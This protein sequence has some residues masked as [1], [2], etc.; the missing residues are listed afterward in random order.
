MQTDVCFRPMLLQNSASSAAGP[1]GTSG[2]LNPNPPVQCLPG[3]PCCSCE[4]E[5]KVWIDPAAG[6]IVAARPG[7]AHCGHCPSL[8]AT[9]RIANSYEGQKST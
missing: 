2:G 5:R 6:H 1:V 3:A 4:D 8:G 9:L 7:L